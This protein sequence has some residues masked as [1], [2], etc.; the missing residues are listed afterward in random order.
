MCRMPNK[1]I[2]LLKKY[3]ATKKKMRDFVNLQFCIQFY[4]IANLDCMKTTTRVFPT[5]LQCYEHNIPVNM[6]G[7]FL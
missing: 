1:S 2:I 3:E 6:S 4:A 5:F 7:M